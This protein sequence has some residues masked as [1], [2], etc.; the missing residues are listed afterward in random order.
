[1]SHLTSY[2]YSLI[3]FDSTNHSEEGVVCGKLSSKLRMGEAERIL[4]PPVQLYLSPSSVRNVLYIYMIK[5]LCFYSSREK[6]KK[7]FS[8]AEIREIE[9]Y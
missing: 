1:M 2:L 9:F 5:I 8:P 4:H 7:K 3:P 6:E